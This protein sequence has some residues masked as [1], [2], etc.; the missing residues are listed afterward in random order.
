[1]KKTLAIGRLAGAAVLAGSLVAAGSSMGFVSAAT[2]SSNPP[3]VVGQENVSTYNFNPFVAAPDFGTLG[4]I[5]QPLIYFDTVSGKE[6]P[7]LGTSMHWSKGNTVLTVP[8]RHGVTWS[9]G[10]KFTSADVVY[11]Y[12]LIKK[13]PAADLNGLWQQLK[14]VTAKGPYEVSFT[15]K[16]PDVPFATYVLG[17]PIVSKSA[18]GPGD[19][20]KSIGKNPVGTGPYTLK[21][22]NSQY[23][24]F[25]ANDKYWGGMPQVPEVKDMQYNGNDPANL[26]MAKGQVDW[27]GAF[28]PGIQQTFIN[29]DPKYNHYW[30]PAVAPNMLYTNLKDPLLKN[31]AVR[32]AISMAI[33]RQ[34]LYMEGEYGYEPVA[35][36][37]GLVLP[38]QNSWLDPHLTAA[39]KSFTYS[40]TQAMKILENAGFKKNSQGIFTSPS[41][42]PLSFSLQVVAGWTDW[43]TD[44]QLIQQELKAIGIQVNV[45]A[46]PYNTYIANISGPKKSYQLAMSYTIAGPGPYYVFQNMLNSKGSWNIEQLNNPHIDTLLNSFARTTNTKMQHNIMDSIESYMVQQIPS[47]PL[48]YGVSWYEYRDSN[49]VGWPSAKNPYITPD[50]TGSGYADTVTLMH[51]KPRK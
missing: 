48:I 30:F 43:D 33:N 50:P 24:D 27:I 32:K 3:L 4:L 34:Q 12:D 6:Y 37:T 5:Y 22:F 23:I 46:L 20:S 49:Y 17:E 47:I 29:K 18:W 44:C 16:A 51:L 8:L 2:N 10:Q 7:M 1:M 42:K 45:E 13:Y 9:N 25:V 39:Q 41:G 26:A 36:P 40:P 35:S 15:F 28:I 14:S 38:N 21:A 19:P 31:L 11:T